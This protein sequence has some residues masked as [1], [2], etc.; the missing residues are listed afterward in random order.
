L[1]K[2]SFWHQW[3]PSLYSELFVLN[4]FLMIVC[5]TTKPSLFQSHQ[6]ILGINWLLTLA[7]KPE[8]VIMFGFTYETRDRKLRV[9][10]YGLTFSPCFYNYSIGLRN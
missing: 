5:M 7:I 1:G 10:T 9:M 4:A 2:K 3:K 8:I 6:L